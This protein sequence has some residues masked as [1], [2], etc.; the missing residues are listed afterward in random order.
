MDWISNIPVE[1]LLEIIS[2][3]D[4]KTIFQTRIS[5]K[6]QNIISNYMCS[7]Y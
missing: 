3:L 6:F 2:Y 5:T 7:K 4:T 1:L